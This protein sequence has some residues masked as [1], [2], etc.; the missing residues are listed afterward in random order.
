MLYVCRFFEKLF[1]ALPSYFKQTV[2]SV[3]K[4]SESKA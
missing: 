3:V 1:G 4:V 2:G